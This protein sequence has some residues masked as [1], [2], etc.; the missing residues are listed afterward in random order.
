VQRRGGY[1]QAAAC[2]SRMAPL[3]RHP[4]TRH[5]TERGTAAHSPE[6]AATARRSCRGG[7]EP[8]GVGQALDRLRESC[9]DRAGQQRESTGRVWQGPG[10]GL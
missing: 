4:C 8:A 2:S 6:P 3:I 7:R 9:G 5:A 1:T 10:V